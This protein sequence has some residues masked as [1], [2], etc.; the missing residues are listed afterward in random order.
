MY[1]CSIHLETPMLQ[2]HNSV[3][4]KITNMSWMVLTSQNLA[5]TQP[6]KPLLGRWTIVS[7][8][9]VPPRS[10]EPVEPVG[11]LKIRSRDGHCLVYL[12]NHECHDLA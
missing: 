12:T 9:L 8:F 1:I 10:A 3:T 7:N 4:L 11:P 6:Q 2:D 5:H